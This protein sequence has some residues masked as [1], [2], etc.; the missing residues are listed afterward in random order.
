M[1]GDEKSKKW[2]LLREFSQA[3]YN[4]VNR[5][6]ALKGMAQN[7]I[8]TLLILSIVCVIKY[9]ITS[10]VG[11]RLGLFIS[12]ITIMLCI[13][14]FYQTRKYTYYTALDLNKTIEVLRLEEESEGACQF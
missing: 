9:F 8:G 6:D 4:L 12:I 1:S 11:F 7:L 2:V 14:L 3:N 5:W 13:L 10:M